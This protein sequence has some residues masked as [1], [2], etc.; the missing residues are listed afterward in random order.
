MSDYF[1]HLTG[2]G[3]RSSAYQKMALNVIKFYFKNVPGKNIADVRMLR[4]REGRSL[5]VVLSEQEVRAIFDSVENLKYKVILITIYSTGLRVSE[6]LVL[7]KS[8]IDRDRSIIRVVRGV[9]G[10]YSTT[11]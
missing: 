6:A 8:H 2:E 9:Q 7:K 11:R 3:G 4:P 5:P 10:R 1:N